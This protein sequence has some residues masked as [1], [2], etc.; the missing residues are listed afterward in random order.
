V[1][2]PFTLTELAGAT[3]ELTEGQ[4]LTGIFRQVRLYRDHASMS[5]DPDALGF[6]PRHDGSST[7]S[8]GADTG[9]RA[10]SGVGGF[11]ARPAPN[12]FL[13]QLRFASCL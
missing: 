6:D 9:T 10:G 3:E 12:S 7:F 1:L 4:W 2:A 11:F 5:H 13:T 8:R